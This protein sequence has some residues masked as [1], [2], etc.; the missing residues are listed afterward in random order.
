VVHFNEARE[1]HAAEGLEVQ[2]GDDEIKA[3]CFPQPVPGV[4]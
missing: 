1:L 3:F 4:G 2:F